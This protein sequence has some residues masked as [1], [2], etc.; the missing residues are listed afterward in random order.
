MSTT[1]GDIRTRLAYRLAEDSA[2]DDTNE[3]ARRDSFINEGYRKI[4]GE[5]YW[6]FTKTI[7]S[8]SSVNGTE[9]YS[10]PSDF[11]DMIELRLNRRVCVA[12]PETDAL[13]TFN[14]PPTY[15][16]YGSINQKYYVYGEN[17][18]HLIPFPSTTPSTLSVSSITQTSGTATATT[19]TA[20]SLQTNDYV[21]VAGADQSEYNGTVRVLSV[22][23]TTTFTYSV[24]SGATSPATGTITAT[25]QNIVYRYWK[26]VSPL[27]SSTDTIVIPDQ[28]SD[29]LVAYAFG[30]YG[31]MDDSKS[32]SADGFEEYN[33]IL[34]DLKRENNKRLWWNKSTPPQSHEYYQE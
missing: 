26:Y 10:L 6:W 5:G 14:Y 22:P 30:R 19:S 13:A 18:L 4:L 16:Q 34:K 15:Y 32:N 24:D 31:Y 17:E 8:T 7:G 2:P 28:F 12:L 9:I 11:R 29:I 33:Q 27:T 1:L 25:W 3:V 20:H 23:S 21:L